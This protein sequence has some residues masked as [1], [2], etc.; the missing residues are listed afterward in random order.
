MSIATKTVSEYYIRLTVPG[1]RKWR[2]ICC[3][4]ALSGIPMESIPDEQFEL[5]PENGLKIWIDLP[6]GKEVSTILN[7]KEDWD[8]DYY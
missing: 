2:K 4:V 5:M 7:Y 8:W 3:S 6:D 1:L